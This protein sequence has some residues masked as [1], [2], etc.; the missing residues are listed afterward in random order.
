MRKGP[1]LAAG[2]GLVGGSYT[3]RLAP[4][5]CTGRAA[6]GT[7]AAVAI[8]GERFAVV[9]PLLYARIDLVTLDDGT[10]V[11][12]RGG[13]ERDP[14]SP[15]GHPDAQPIAAELVRRTITPG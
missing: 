3:E 5:S 13:G 6:V 2:G 15:G 7:S 10:D 1:L 12:V 4:R 9:D 14:R 8:V 11:S